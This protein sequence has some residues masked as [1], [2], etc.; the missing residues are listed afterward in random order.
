[1]TQ[2]D[3]DNQIPNDRSFIAVTPELLNHLE[4]SGVTQKM[5]DAVAEQCSGSE[6]LAQQIKRLGVTLQ[7]TCTTAP[8]QFEGEVDGLWLYFRARGNHWDC[9]IAPTLDEAVGEVNLAFYKE[10]DYGKDKFDASWMPHKDALKIILD[11]VQEFR[12]KAKE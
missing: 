9:A 11:C 7:C 2:E 4:K 5:R 1:M 8:V 3:S 12:A 6:A 10:A